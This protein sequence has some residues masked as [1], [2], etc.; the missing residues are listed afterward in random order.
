MKLKNLLISVGAFALVSSLAVGLVTS[1]DE[2][3]RTEAATNTWSII[4]GFT[5]SNW[6]TDIEF[7]DEDA[8]GIGEI[9]LELPANTGFKFRW[10]SKWDQQ[11]NGGAWT[12]KHGTTDFSGSGS[13]NIVAKKAGIYTFTMSMDKVRSSSATASDISYT[14][15]EEEVVVEGTWAMIGSYTGSNWAT[16][17][18]F[19]LDETS[20][21]YVITK[22]LSANDE[23][24]FRFNN[25]NTSWGIEIGAGDG[26]T[27]EKLG[28]KGGNFLALASATYKFTMSAE[29]YV[30]Y[31]STGS[32][33]SVAL[34]NVDE[35]VYGIESGKPFYLEISI[36]KDEYNEYYTPENNWT[37]GGAVFYLNFGIGHGTED[38][39]AWSAKMTKVECAG[40][41]TVVVYETIVPTDSEGNAVVW[42]SVNAVRIN[43]SAENPSWEDGV[44]W[45]DAYHAFTNATQDKNM[46]KVYHWEYSEMV[47]PF[48]TEGRATVFGKYFDKVAVC[49][50]NGSN[51]ITEEQWNSVK[52]QYDAMHADAK[53]IVEKTVAS[54]AEEAT[55]LE[56]SMH[57]YDYLVAKYAGN[58][59]AG[60]AWMTDFIGRVEV[61]GANRLMTSLT[62]N[63]N[64]VM[65]IVISSVVAVLGVSVFFIYRR[66]RNVQ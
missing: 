24:K 6:A 51:T 58:T 36:V 19:V 13:D 52:A 63:N 46:I 27:H 26:L 55:D 23:F 33:I 7:T 30:D 9:K 31:T 15:A 11:I 48:T 65:I 20:G 45:G 22:E 47:G 12:S 60:K 64:M 44:K 38:E 41:E 1:H 2:M 10:N 3:I 5:E 50:G 39:D 25:D 32:D 43:P 37:S 21:N 42:G 61:T 56:K 17:T 35:T 18:E 62:N 29:A 66:K 8:D 57:K 34:E 4:G 28:D 14:Y 54:D 16:E 59:F 49:D 53:T 40:D